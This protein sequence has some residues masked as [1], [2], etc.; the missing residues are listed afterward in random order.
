MKA[1]ANQIEL[2]DIDKELKRLWDEE[3][4]KN[5][6]RACLFTLIVYT[7]KK[8]DD[9]PWKD[10]VHSII[11]SFPCRVIYIHIDETSHD[12]LKTRVSTETVT[13]ETFCEIIDIEASGALLERVPYILLP[14]IVPDLPLYLL[15]TQ[16]PST[17]KIILPSLK[18]YAKRIIFD[19]G[20][21]PD[22]SRFTKEVLTLI[23]SFHCEVGDLNWSA[24]KGWRKIFANLFETKEKLEALENANKIT[25]TYHS[26]T[27]QA[28]PEIRAIYFQ[29]WLAAIF[30]WKCISKN[31][32]KN[33]ISL[34]Y[35]DKTPLVIELIGEE[36]FSLQLPSGALLSIEVNSPLRESHFSC[37]RLETTSQV[38]IQHSDTVS[39]ALPTCSNL[40]STFE[41]QE[42][43]QELFYPHSGK[44]YRMM[45]EN[46]S[47]I[48]WD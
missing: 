46:I 8:D 10:H 7:K 11:S 28:H 30:N 39:C 13:P 22:F 45:L 19:A 20:S 44:H 6:V 47:K 5:K 33:K 23:E 31:I 32:Q 25:I 14:L 9:D 27:N 2:V 36:N 40:S 4:G 43:L 1:M 16:D 38:F 12:M 48:S 15:W 21:T 34:T 29:G 3:E 42:I 24:I 37:K 26:S 17:D 35:C 41:G 18:P